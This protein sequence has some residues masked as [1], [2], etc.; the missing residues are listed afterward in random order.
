MGFNSDF[1]IRRQEDGQIGGTEVLQILKLVVLSST[2]KLPEPSRRTLLLARSLALSRSRSL[3]ACA[4][5][6]ARERAYM[7]DFRA[8]TIL[9]FELNAI[10]LYS[11]AKPWTNTPQP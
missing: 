11:V 9:R 5:V 8:G 7:R 3:S 2:R 10:A 6:R 4:L 1:Q